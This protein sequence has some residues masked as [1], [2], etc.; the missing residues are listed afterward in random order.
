MGVFWDCIEGL[1]EFFH[2]RL[3]KGEY[4]LGGVYGLA[5]YCLGGTPACVSFLQRLDINWIKAVPIC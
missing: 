4:L 3:W 2:P 5:E 1:V